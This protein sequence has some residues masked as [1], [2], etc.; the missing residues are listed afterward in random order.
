[1]HPTRR[2]SL[3]A[4]AS[5]LFSI[6]WELETV[7]GLGFLLLFPQSGHTRVS[8]ILAHTVLPRCPDLVVDI[9]QFLENRFLCAKVEV[10]DKTELL[11]LREITLLLKPALQVVILLVVTFVEIL[12]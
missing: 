9:A 10:V 4:G 1:M 2:R 7:V 6:Y 3:L 5:S 8:T 11:F 12:E